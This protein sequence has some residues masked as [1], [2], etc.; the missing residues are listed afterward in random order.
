[1]FLTRIKRRERDFGSQKLIGG[2][3]SPDHDEQVNAQERQ[4]V[5]YNLHLLEGTSIAPR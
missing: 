1:M 5:T 2:K 3:I 4:F